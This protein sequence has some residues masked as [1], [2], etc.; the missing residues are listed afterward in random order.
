M[1]DSDHQWKR[2]ALDRMRKAY[3]VMKLG[4]REFWR[5]VHLSLEVALQ[6]ED[7]VIPLVFL[8]VGTGTS[9]GVILLTL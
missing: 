7:G 2:L 1:N 4:L 6:S 9:K 5:N 3:A 8:H